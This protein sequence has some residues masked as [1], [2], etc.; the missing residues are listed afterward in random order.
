MDAGLAACS[1]SG[2]GGLAALILRL[3]VA[4]GMNMLRIAGIGAYESETF[5][6][7]CDELGILVW[8]DFMFANLD[9][10]ESDPQFLPAG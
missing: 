4:G 5:Y 9:Y 3:V 10:P 1:G 7:R 6:D 2:H 8:Q